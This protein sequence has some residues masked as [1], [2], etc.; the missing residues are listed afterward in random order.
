MKYLSAISIVLFLAAG[1]A[2]VQGWL[3]THATVPAA[4]SVGFVSVA[5]AFVRDGL[6]ATLR[7]DRSPPLF[8]L[9]VY[10]SHWT[11]SRWGSIAENDW[12]TA[13][14]V[15]AAVPLALA[16]GVSWLLFRRSVPTMA[17][18]LAAGFGCVLTVVARLGA[19]GLSDSTH[20]AFL[21]IG[22]AALAAALDGDASNVFS[23]STG[24]RLFATGIALACAQLTRVDAAIVIPALVIALAIEVFVLK[25]IR[26][27]RALLSCA[28]VMAGFLLV[29][30]PYLVVSQPA[31]PAEAVAR[32][33]GLRGPNDRV[34]LNLT[35]ENAVTVE[36]AP[37]PDWR[38]ADGQPMAFGRSDPSHSIHFRSRA[39][40]CLEFVR[41]VAQ[42]LNYLLG[43]LALLGLWFWRSKIRRPI[44][45]FLILL[46]LVHV[47]CVLAV[48]TTRGY[49]AGRHVL[50][51][52]WLAL[53]WAGLGICRL[54]QLTA[55]CVGRWLHRPPAAYWELFA[56]LGLAA[57]VCAGCLATTLVP[58][59]KSH[60]GH[61]RAVEWLAT[62]ADDGAV[63]DSAGYT[64]LYSGRKTYRYAAARDA[65]RDPEL[66]YLVIERGE[67]TADT[68][69]GATLRELLGQFAEP[70]AIFAPPETKAATRTV[71]LYRWR[72]WE[73]AHHIRGNHAR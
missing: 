27:P 28:S 5:Q 50:L 25:R 49:L 20:L 51:I 32:L 34:P 31:G 62:E 47:S 68:P 13:A 44:D 6:P 39:T 3:I 67:L 72:P 38:L 60:S 14:Q 19:D 53:P 16:V 71:L 12:G 63:L 65:L 18:I 11:L 26:L 10:A 58:L 30:V 24:A 41:E 15:A 2:L 54:G 55:A 21:T 37:K 29:A 56:T 70:E 66:A 36:V 23:R 9:L 35:A 59:H 45:V 33:W 8:P 7:N 1:S 52:A 40:A 69:R 46:V 48:A 43:P 57:A 22:L 73:F 61:Q 4:D 64:A 17:A 42:S